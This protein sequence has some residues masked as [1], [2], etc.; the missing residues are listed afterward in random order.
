MTQFL[1]VGLI[2]QDWSEGTA[3]VHPFKLGDGAL[4]KSGK[5]IKFKVFRKKHLLETALV[6]EAKRAANPHIQAVDIAEAAGLS[7][8]RVHQIL[9]FA[10]LH[11]E[12]REAILKLSPKQAKKRFP[13]RLLRKW[14]PLSNEGQLNQFRPY[15]L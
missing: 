4:R 14:T 8:C 7:V 5:A 3:V 13:E 2:H 12:I 10:R 15:S 9:R 11:P 1:I 6:W